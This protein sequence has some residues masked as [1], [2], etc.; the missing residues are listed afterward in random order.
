MPFYLK[1]T[2]LNDVL[3]KGGFS[4][5]DQQYGT[6]GVLTLH[7]NILEILEVQPWCCFPTC[8]HTSM[9][10]FLRGSPKGLSMGS[11]L[12]TLGGCKCCT[13]L[14]KTIYSFSTAQSHFLEADVVD[15]YFVPREE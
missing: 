5:Q 1:D 2:E 3:F 15:P 4:N 8:A 14:V 13:I 12:L 9:N 7:E 6:K 10:L 11:S